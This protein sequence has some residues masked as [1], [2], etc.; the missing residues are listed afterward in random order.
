MKAAVRGVA[1]LSR[2]EPVHRP[3]PHGGVRAVVG[4]ALDHGVARAA[5]G[6]VDVSVTVARVGRIEQVRET[7][8]TYRKVRRNTYGRWARNLAL[9]N[10][11][12]LEAGLLAETHFDGRDQCSGG[13]CPFEVVEKCPQRRLISLQMNVHPMGLVQNPSSE[14]VLPRQA[15]DEG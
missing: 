3:A 10:G 14:G 4:E 5:I 15:E 1:V 2:A 11:E 9:A 8:F 7:I 13:S 6:A 12:I